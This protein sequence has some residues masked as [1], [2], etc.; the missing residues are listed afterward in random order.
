MKKAVIK[1]YHCFYANI[2]LIET[3]CDDVEG[4]SFK[5]DSVAKT[6][7]DFDHFNM[8]KASSIALT[9]LSSL[10]QPR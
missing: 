1:K 4:F 6:F 2:L 9:T 8:R 10:C 3:Q 7:N 5:R